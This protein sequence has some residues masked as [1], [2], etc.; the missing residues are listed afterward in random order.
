MLWFQNVVKKIFVHRLEICK[1]RCFTWWL[2][3]G[4]THFAL[5][6]RSG[7]LQYKIFA[8]GITG[9]TGLRWGKT[10][11]CG[12]NTTWTRL[13]LSNDD[14]PFHVFI[15]SLYVQCFLRFSSCA[16]NGPPGGPQDQNQSHGPLPGGHDFEHP[17]L[18]IS[19]Q[20][21][22]SSYLPSITGRNFANHSTCGR[23]CSGD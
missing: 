4:G 14:V 23:N 6:N 19:T 16:L 22:T 7:K 20:H 11:V 15:C 21:A 17:H 12:S 5:E 1:P 13:L 18:L 8:N 2:L 9:A 10:A 3:L